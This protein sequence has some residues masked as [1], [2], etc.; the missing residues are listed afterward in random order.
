MLCRSPCFQ[1]SRI[2]FS[3]DIPHC[4]QYYSFD[5]FFFVSISNRLKQALSKS[6]ADLKTM[7]KV[8]ISN[9]ELLQNLQAENCKLRSDIS[10][11]ALRFEADRHES[12]RKIDIQL[13]E[14]KQLEG[15]LL[16]TKQMADL[17]LEQHAQ[18]VSNL[19]EKLSS[20]QLRIEQLIRE[21]VEEKLIADR[22]VAELQVK[23]N[24]A[25]KDEAQQKKVVFP[26]KLFSV[27]ITLF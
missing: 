6:Q 16:G 17:A 8:A 4:T 18:Q 9:E 10:D 2:Y 21:N 14:K 12:Q 20:A 13:Q 15:K 1:G 25:M 3:C 26:S 11:Q 7:K 23:V 24:H 5:V 27:L 22:T 19:E